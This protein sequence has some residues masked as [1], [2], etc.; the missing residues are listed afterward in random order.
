MLRRS[1]L[2]CRLYASVL[3]RRAGLICF[4][5]LP[6]WLFAGSMVSSSSGETNGVKPQ[7]PQKSPVAFTP[8][9]SLP[10][11]ARCLPDMVDEYAPQLMRNRYLQEQH[12]RRDPEAN[13]YGVNPED[14]FYF[15]ADATE[16]DAGQK[17]RE[18]ARFA[19][20]LKIR[21][22]EAGDTY[23]WRFTAKFSEFDK[24]EYGY[25]LR[26]INGRAGVYVIPTLKGTRNLEKDI[27]AFR[28]RLPVPDVSPSLTGFAGGGFSGGGFDRNA[29]LTGQIQAAE[30]TLLLRRTSPPV[31][32]LG[33]LDPRYCLITSSANRTQR[34]WNTPDASSV[35]TD[36]TDK[37]ASVSEMIYP[38]LFFNSQIYLPQS[39]KKVSGDGEYEIELEFQVKAAERRRHPLQ[40]TSRDLSL[41]MPKA[42]EGNGCYVYYYAEITNARLLNPESNQWHQLRTKIW[43]SLDTNSHLILHSSERAE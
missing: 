6:L 10:M 30:Q 3:F 36:S 24:T 15:Q 35:E 14:G 1:Q 27:Q 4:G 8:A 43:W 32:N 2:F 39:M 41:L 29:Q 16:P 11:L 19:N 31:I 25:P 12:F 21:G 7:S 23:R 33:E 42:V 40:T 22:K 34:E 17:S 26:E 37:N 38:G 28:S 13:T 18:K 9:N 20:W 5:L